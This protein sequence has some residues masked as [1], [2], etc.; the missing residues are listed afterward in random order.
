MVAR[1]MRASVALHS[2][3]NGR[4]RQD[5]RDKQDGNILPFL[6]FRPFLPFLPFLPFSER[7]LDIELRGPRRPAVED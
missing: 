6:P 4:E 5:G 2:G 1:F 3:Q 7:V